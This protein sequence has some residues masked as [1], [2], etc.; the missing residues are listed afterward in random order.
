[1]VRDLKQLLM[2]AFLKILQNDDSN[3]CNNHKTLSDF[4]T[5]AQMPCQD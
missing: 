3:L 2:E 1:M 4:V 5:Q